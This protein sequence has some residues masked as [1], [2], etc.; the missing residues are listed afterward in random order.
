[1]VIN[2]YLAGLLTVLVVAVTAF[3]AALSDGFTTTEAWQLSG[4]VLGAFVTVFVPL[5]E[6]PWAAALKVGG[7]VLGAA[8]AAIVPFVTGGWDAS[9]LTI[10][11]LAVLNTLTT[12]LGVDV[13]LD[14]A[15]AVLEDPQKSNRLA[16]AVDPK[17]V[18]LVGPP[19]S[20]E[21]LT[22]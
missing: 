1:M 4:L 19:T 6:K 11:V 8:I 12:Q 13:R 20:T 14:S 16:S 3:Q 22:N 10:V 17:A 5:L 18:A 21:P 9:A 2:K 7:A 15:K